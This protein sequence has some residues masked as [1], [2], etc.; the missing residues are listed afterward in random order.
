MPAEVL[1]ILTLAASPPS[2]MAPSFLEGENGVNEKAVI[3][4][5]RVA[6][7][8]SNQRQARCFASVLAGR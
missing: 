3:A 6:V 2:A 5:V 8:G 1:T 4:G 7:S